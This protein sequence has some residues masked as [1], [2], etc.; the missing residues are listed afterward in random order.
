MRKRKLKGEVN[1]V[2]SL[3]DAWELFKDTILEAE[4]GVSTA[5]RAR[6]MPAWLRSRVK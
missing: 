6:R 1:K 5:D 3:Q 4:S 2:E